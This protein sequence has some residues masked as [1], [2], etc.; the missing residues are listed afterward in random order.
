MQASSADTF[1]N[2][3]LTYSFGDNFNCPVKSSTKYIHEEGMPEWK[4]ATARAAREDHEVGIDVEG[5]ANTATLTQN[6]QEEHRLPGTFFPRSSHV[7]PGV[8]QNVHN[9]A[10]VRIRTLGQPSA[11][12]YSGP[13]TADILNQSPPVVSFQNEPVS[14]VKGESPVTVIDERMFNAYDCSHPHNLRVADA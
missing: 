7:M 6:T 2:D 13:T 14:Q 10:E 11:E 5:E 9:K 8:V 12:S 4:K 1:I 3:L